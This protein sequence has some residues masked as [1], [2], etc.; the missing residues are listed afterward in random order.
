MNRFDLLRFDLQ[1]LLGHDQNLELA[2]ARMLS[3]SLRFCFGIGSELPELV[4]QFRAMNLKAV[5][6]QKDVAVE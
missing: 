5:T 1:S 6:S 3:L 4:F 2:K